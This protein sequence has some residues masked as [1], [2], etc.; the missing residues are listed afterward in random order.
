MLDAAGVKVLN[1]SGIG[2]GQYLAKELESNPR[3]IIPWDET[4]GFFA[5]TGMQNSTLLSVLKSLYEGNSAW[6][7]SLTNKKFGTDEAHLSVLL[8]STRTSFVEGF[9]LRGGVGD[10]LLSRFTLVY[11]AGMPAVPVWQE[12][13][14]AEERQSV[15]RISALIPA[16]FVPLDIDEKARERF[17]E[18]ARLLLS[19][20][21][22]HPDHVR[23]LPELTKVDLLLRAV[24]SGSTIITLEMVDRAITWGEHQ[25]ALRL[26]LW[27]VDAT[28]KVESMTQVLLRRLK[29]GSA[30]AN[31]LRRAANLDRDG[32]HETFSRAMTALKRSGALIILG[33]NRKGREVFGLDVD[34][35]DTEVAQ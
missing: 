25:L 26:A 17:V 4:T 12:R 20:Q 22:P 27:P 28:D 31:D 24:F 9:K 13:N 18:F 8:H 1:G 34:D 19:P 32:C 35:S 3:A 16:R 33:K 30:S 14:F 6:T 7:G 11:S 15:E 10:G 21:H 23:R 5:Q 2:S 29:K